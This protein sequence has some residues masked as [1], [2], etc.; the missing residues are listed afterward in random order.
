MT[1]T[2]NER[3][4]AVRK[5]L[6]LSQKEFAKTLGLTQ[7][8]Y[9]DAETG[10]NNITEQLKTILVSIHNINKT[11]LEQGKGEMFTLSKSETK[12]T[13]EELDTKNNTI[14]LLNADIRRLNAERELY[15]KLLDSKD[16]IIA[17]L[18]QIIKK[19]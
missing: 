8:G 15:L 5:A 9:S 18:E 6:N 19:E 7:T 11:W 4:K 1:K 17:G 3:I 12:I 13:F 14:E 16:K 2:I 10:K